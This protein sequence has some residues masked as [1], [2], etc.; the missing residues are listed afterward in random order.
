MKKN[1]V[2]GLMAIGLVIFGIFTALSYATL[3]ADMPMQIGLTGQ[4]NWTLPKPLA[5]GAM[6][7]LLGAVSVQFIVHF[8]QQDQAGLNESLVV[9]LLPLA[10]T[11]FLWFAT[12]LN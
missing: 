1:L 12:T 2:Y 5:I 9:I 10:L 8:R 3:P 7:I 6:A 4:V 11:G